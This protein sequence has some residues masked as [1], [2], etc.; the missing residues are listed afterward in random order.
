MDRGIVH[1]HGYA[2]KQCYVHPSVT[3]VLWRNNSTC[4]FLLSGSPTTLVIWQ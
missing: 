1:K 4:H 3:G 2:L